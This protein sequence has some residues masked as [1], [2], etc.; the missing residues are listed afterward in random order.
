MRWFLKIAV[1]C[2]IVLFLGVFITPLMDI[3]WVNYPMVSYKYK[4]LITMLF[5][6]GIVII[7]TGYLVA[8]YL[9][10]IQFKEMLLIKGYSPEEIEMLQYMDFNEWY[11]KVNPKGFEEWKN[12]KNELMQPK[13]E[14]QK[15]KNKPKIPVIVSNKGLVVGAKSNIIC[16][17]CGSPIVPIKLKSGDLLCPICGINLVEGKGSSIGEKNVK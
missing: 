13:I 17:S 15:M 14:E 5:Y 3:I 6:I 4:D 2:I 1:W 10:E 12:R 7:G 8:K 11:K 9:N 16:P